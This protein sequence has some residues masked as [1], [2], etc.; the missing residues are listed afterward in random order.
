MIFDVLFLYGAVFLIDKF[1]PLYQDPAALKKA[2]EE[3]AKQIKNREDAK[4]IIFVISWF[5][6]VNFEKTVNLFH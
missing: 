4:V 2:R 1:P 6:F 3:A 5:I